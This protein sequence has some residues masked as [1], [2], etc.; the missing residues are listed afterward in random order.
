MTELVI[1]DPAQRRDLALFADRLVR[2]DPGAVVRLRVRSD[3]LVAAW[4]RTPFDVL[5]C[6]VVG[7]DLSPADVTCGARELSRGE[8]GPPMDFAWRGVLPPDGGFVHIDDVPASVVMSLKESQALE[9]TDPTTT[10]TVPSQC[11]QA[12]AALGFLPDPLPAQEVV[13]VRTTR[14]WLRLDAR[15]GSVFLRRVRT[16]S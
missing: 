4:A 11:A 12:L 1:A 13:R 7:A 10:V 2:L 14:T 9:V 5:A 15:F 16:G 3:G 8:P 6:R